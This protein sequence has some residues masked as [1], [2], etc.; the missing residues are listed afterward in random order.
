MR[1]RLRWSEWS[2]LLAALAWLLLSGAASRAGEG[3]DVALGKK[4]FVSGTT[5]ACPVCHTLED[6]GAAGSIGPSLDELKPD[7]ERVKKAVKNGI[8]QMP[9]FGTLTEREVEAIARYVAQASGAAK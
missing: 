4:L 3:A 9:A 6:A 5:P 7:A 8:G 2:L 1:C